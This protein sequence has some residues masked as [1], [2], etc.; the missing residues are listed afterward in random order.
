MTEAEI[1]AAH[2][3]WTDEQVWAYIDERDLPVNRLH[4][5]G[6]ASIGCIH[7]TRPGSGRE[8]R[9]AGNEKTECGLHRPA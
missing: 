3:D 7:C 4:A 9:W 1:R 6:Y 8:G 2:P 5:Q